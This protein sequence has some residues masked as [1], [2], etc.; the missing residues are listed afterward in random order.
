MAT[1]SLARVVRAIFQPSLTVP[2]WN[3]SGTNRSSRNTSLNSDSPV[4]SR[5]G[6]VR[7]PSERMSTRK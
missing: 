6:E 3:S 5:S 2:I 4:I 1:R 7:M